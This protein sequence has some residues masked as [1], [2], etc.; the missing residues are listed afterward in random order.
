MHKPVTGRHPIF[1]SRAVQAGL[2]P[3]QPSGIQVTQFCTVGPLS[4]LHI[5]GIPKD[6]RLQQDAQLLPR[7]AICMMFRAPFESPGMRQHHSRQE[8]RSV[9]SATCRNSEVKT[10]SA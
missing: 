2:H 8:K 10:A 1:W 7:Y 9:Y 6:R 3:R 5:R 4:T